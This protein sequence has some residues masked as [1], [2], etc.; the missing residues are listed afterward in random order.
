MNKYKIY[1]NKNQK[2]KEKQKKLILNKKLNKIYILKY[3][4]MMNYF[5]IKN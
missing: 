2:F 4:N 3:K 1:N 5:N